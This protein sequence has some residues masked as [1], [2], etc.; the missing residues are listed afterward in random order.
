[1]SFSKRAMEI[2]ETHA[3]FTDIHFQDLH[4][5]QKDWIILWLNW[6]IAPEDWNILPENLDK[7]K[8]LVLDWWK[9]IV[10][11]DAEGIT[12]CNELESLWIKVMNLNFKKPN[13]RWFEECIKYFGEEWLKENN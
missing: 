1:M 13:V 2:L 11:S 6:T 8:E 4:V 12:K 5:Y 10:Y 9:I 7:I 3:K